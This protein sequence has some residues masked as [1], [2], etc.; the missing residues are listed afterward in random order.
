MAVADFRLSSKHK[1]L[2]VFEGNMPG[3][4]EHPKL[5]LA[6]V[7]EGSSCLSVCVVSLLGLKWTRAFGYLQGPP[8]SLRSEKGESYI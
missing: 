2:Y 1:R 5:S 3:K 8:L 4:P 7:S 6:A